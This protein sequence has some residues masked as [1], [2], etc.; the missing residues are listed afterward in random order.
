MNPQKADRTEEIM[1]VNIENEYESYSGF[2]DIM[3]EDP[4]QIVE[5][6]VLAVLD[7]EENP[8]EC[9]V[10]VLF[11]G[12]SEI[13]EI[14]REQRNIDRS[15]DVL[16]FPM[17]EYERP[18][19]FDGFDDMDD[20]FHPDTGE[21]MLGDIVI[22]IDHVISQAEEYG[23]SRE[24]EL[25]FLVVHSMLHLHG[26]DHMEDQERL[27]MEDRQRTILDEAGFHR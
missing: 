16:S 12:D 7:A 23:H 24:R 3:K 1:T 10:N 9:E 6:A 15:T 5:K 25:A 21:L 4:R 13:R 22:S 27:V 17:V 8:Y 20:L 11:T 18:S 2:C 26:Y 14:N 19:C